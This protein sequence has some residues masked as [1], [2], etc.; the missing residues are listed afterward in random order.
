M[1]KLL[2]DDDKEL[3]QVAIGSLAYMLSTE[4]TDEFCKAGAVTLLLELLPQLKDTAKCGAQVIAALWTLTFSSEMARDEVR[5]LKG[6][7]ILF[8]IIRESNDEFIQEQ[9]LDILENMCGST[10]NQN[11]IRLSGGF[12]LLKEVLRIHNPT[13]NRKTCSTLTALIASN[14]T[15]KKYFEEKKLAKKMVE[16]IY[17]KA[18]RN[19]RVAAARTLKEWINKSERQVFSDG[20]GGEDLD[21]FLVMSD[22]ERNEPE[23]GGKKIVKSRS[24]RKYREWLHPATP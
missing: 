23:F 17:S 24:L 12:E 22:S 13:L 5:E 15:N 8:N 7:P 9:A 3:Q 2:V 6:L 14:S 19:V 4:T 10:Q 18:D 21:A 20:E 1:L 16:L 11:E